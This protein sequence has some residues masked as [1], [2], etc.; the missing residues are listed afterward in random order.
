MGN[1][2]VKL[3]IAPV[4]SST[5][6]LD[7]WLYF[8]TPLRNSS[9]AHS[10]SLFLRSSFSFPPSPGVRVNS[11]L[12]LHRVVF[13]GMCKFCRT[14]RFCCRL[15]FTFAFFLFL[16]FFWIPFPVLFRNL[17]VYNLS[18]IKFKKKK[19]YNSCVM[20]GVKGSEDRIVGNGR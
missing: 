19:M 9:R 7:I 3:L 1:V 12:Q 17:I 11:S 13:R 20:Y 14:H 6:V 5:G 8:K 10:L 2:N 16:F 4:F 18:I 15:Y